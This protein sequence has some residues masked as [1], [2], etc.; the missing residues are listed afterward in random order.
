MKKIIF[1]FFIIV[2]VYFMSGCVNNNNGNNVFPDD[3]DKKP[4]LYLY[5]EKETN[6][7]VMIEKPKLLNTTYPKYNKGWNVIVKPNGDMVDKE[8]KHYYA[9]YWDEDNNTKEEYKEGFYVTKEDALDFLE[10][11]LSY[12]GLN[13]NEKNEFIMYWLPILEKNDKN[14]VR[15]SFTEELQNKNAIIIEPKPDSMLRVHI[16]IKKVNKKINI[17]EQKL[18]KFDRKGYTAVEWGGRIIE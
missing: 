13:D 1:S 8:G 2:F 7:N 5:P 3:G 9:L 10:E 15:F 18:E 12:I 11:K 14:I 4:I 6:I 17:K 16:N